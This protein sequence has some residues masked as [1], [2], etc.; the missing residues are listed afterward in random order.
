M[1]IY[2]YED[3]EISTEYGKNFDG[4][5]PEVTFPSLEEVVEYIDSADRWDSVENGVY[6]E[7]CDA[8]G[9]NYY[10][11]DDPDDMMEAV[12]AEMKRHR[13]L[14]IV[15]DV[16]KSETAKMK[17]GDRDTFFDILPEEDTLDQAIEKADTEWKSLH[18][19]DR[20]QQR[21][22]LCALDREDD[23]IVDVIKKYE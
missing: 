10:D 20:R 4:T 15:S 2:K 23:A 3:G 5:Y 8:V 6:V 13:K 17:D 7:L 16:Y 9:L 21:L 12:R 18:W 19:R 11:Y 22:F 14:A 1:A